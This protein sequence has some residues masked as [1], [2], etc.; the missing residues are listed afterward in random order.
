[1]GKWT[2]LRFSRGMPRSSRILTPICFMVMT[3]EEN[4]KEDV[5]QIRCRLTH[6]DVCL[7]Q[8]PH[9][10]CIKDQNQCHPPDL[11]EEF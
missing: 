6:G 8:Y 10:R 2:Y 7:V 9:G 1:M 5:M 4:A 11:A 3:I